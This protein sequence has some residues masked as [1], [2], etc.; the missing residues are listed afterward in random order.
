MNYIDARLAVF[1]IKIN[2]IKNSWLQDGTAASFWHATTM[3][4]SR[5]NHRLFDN[6]Y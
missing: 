5:N 2:D 4:L 1:S 3:E 6:N